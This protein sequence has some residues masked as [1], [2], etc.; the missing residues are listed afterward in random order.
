[1]LSKPAVL[2]MRAISIAAH[3]PHRHRGDDLVAR[4]LLLHVVAQDVADL[5]GGPRLVLSCPPG[6]TRNDGRIRTR[7]T[8]LRLDGRMRDANRVT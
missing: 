4:E 2:A 3:Q 1:M 8:A 5:H 6:Y 7:H